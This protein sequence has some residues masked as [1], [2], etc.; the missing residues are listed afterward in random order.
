MSGIKLITRICSALIITTLSFY[1]TP[2]ANNFK[3]IN[4][5]DPNT[6]KDAANKKYVDDI[7][8]SVRIDINS[9]KGILNEIK[10]F[11]KN[12]RQ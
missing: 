7:A 5:G 8:Q 9:N 1:K 11:I 2:N 6:D 3:I 4:L 12:F 10:K